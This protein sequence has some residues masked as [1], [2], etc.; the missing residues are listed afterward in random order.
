MN[1][2]FLFINSTDRYA[3]TI[4]V[5]IKLFFIFFFNQF[6]IRKYN[7]IIYLNFSLDLF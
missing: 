2:D 4:Q 3:Q 1:I 5:E 6:E 7:E